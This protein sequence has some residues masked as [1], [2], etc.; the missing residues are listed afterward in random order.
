M[1]SRHREL[2]KIYGKML[3]L[4]LVISGVV[5]LVMNHFSE[6]GE[7][8]PALPEVEAEESGR[9]SI[10]AVR[11]DLNEKKTKIGAVKE[12]GNK[13][14]TVFFSEPRRL[15]WTGLKAKIQG[16]KGFEARFDM[17]LWGRDPGFP[18]EASRFRESIEVAVANIFYFS[19]Q[20]ERDIPDLSRRIRDEI[21]RLLP[22]TQID[23][24]QLRN[25]QLGSIEK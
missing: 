12:E 22:E 2:V 11:E 3:L 18:P 8:L 20:N 14:K 9:D 6:E 1:I 5:L 13:K 10:F 4:S 16:V 7:T 24:V 25:I 19:G 23:S 15:E 17:T 21:N